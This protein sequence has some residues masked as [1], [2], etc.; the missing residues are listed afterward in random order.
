MCDSLWVGV[1]R[2]TFSS[3]R[4][5]V[6]VQPM[7]CSV[8]A[9]SQI[10]VASVSL[11]KILK[12]PVYYRCSD[13]TLLSDYHTAVEH[14]RRLP[15]PPGADT[16][17]GVPVEAAPLVRL[18]AYDV[19][20]PVRAFEDRDPEKGRYQKVRRRAQLACGRDGE[21][22]LVAHVVVPLAVCACVC[23]CARVWVCF[24][25]CQSLP[26]SARVMVES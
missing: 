24:P 7:L 11:H 1:S 26:V 25:G 3:H 9:D 20:V 13:G 6:C 22:M 14:Q 21:S 4:L 23:V 2:H 15:T 16:V 8:A 10:G 18:Q 17:E 12:N 5:V 19:W